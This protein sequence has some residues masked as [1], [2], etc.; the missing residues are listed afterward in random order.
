MKLDY[1]S[2]ETQQMVHGING[3][4]IDLIK[5]LT[6]RSCDY[7]TFEVRLNDKIVKDGNQWMNRQPNS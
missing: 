5:N 2:Q 7:L 3:C 1:P 6:A 4:E